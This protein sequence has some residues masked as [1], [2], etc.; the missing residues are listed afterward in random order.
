ME[1]INVNS[2]RWWEKDWLIKRKVNGSIELAEKLCELS[3]LVMKCEA[4]KWV[5]NGAF[6]NMI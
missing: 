6:Y 2:V 3:C 1:L 4:T 5:I